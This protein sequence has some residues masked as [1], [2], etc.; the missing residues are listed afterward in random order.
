MGREGVCWGEGREAWEVCVRECGRRD[1]SV[2]VWACIDCCQGDVEGG[3]A[4]MID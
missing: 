3:L 4:I 2:C 1:K